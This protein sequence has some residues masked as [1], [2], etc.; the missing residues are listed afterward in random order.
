M[1][2]NHL[3]MPNA[4]QPLAN[5]QDLYL[6][7]VRVGIPNAV[8]DNRRFLLHFYSRNPTASRQTPLRYDGQAPIQ[9]YIPLANVT[10]TSAPNAIPNHSVF[11]GYSTPN[12][13]RFTQWLRT[14]I[15]VPAGRQV[16]VQMQHQQTQLDGFLTE[17]ETEIRQVEPTALL[18]RTVTLL[19]IYWWLWMRNRRLA[20]LQQSGWEGMGEHLE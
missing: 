19:G 5:L 16:P 13:T 20:D 6:W 8:I 18:E 15:H 11:H 1:L 17:N 12:E 9:N 7:L 14:A 4:I 10:Q 2:L 3:Q